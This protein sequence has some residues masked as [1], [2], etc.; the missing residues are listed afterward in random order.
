MEGI[1]GNSISGCVN[2]LKTKTHKC[3]RNCGPIWLSLRIQDQTDGFP[4][5]T[6]QVGRKEIKDTAEMPQ[7]Q[8]RTLA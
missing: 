5:S 3:F 2:T 7:N 6:G 8:V 4:S 1:W